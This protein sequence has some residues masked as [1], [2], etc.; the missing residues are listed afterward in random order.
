[1]GGKQGWL[2]IDILVY[3]QLKASSLCAEVTRLGC[4]RSLCLSAYIV[5][6]HASFPKKWNLCKTNGTDLVTL[7]CNGAP[8]QGR[9]RMTGMYQ[10]G[11][12][13]SVQV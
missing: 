11:K 1:M 5:R 13:N 8:G 12:S 6:A 3:G 7:S 10:D 2:L 9:P 4:L